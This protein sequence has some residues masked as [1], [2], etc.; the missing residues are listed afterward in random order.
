MCNGPVLKTWEAECINY[1]L[2]NPNIELKLIIRDT[3]ENYG[4][5]SILKKIFKLPLNNIFFLFYSKLIIRPHATRNT[6]LSNIISNIPSITCK[7]IKKGKHSQ[8]FSQEDIL[9]IKGFN[10]DFILRFGF[11]IIRGEILNCSRYGIWSFHHD[12]EQKYRGSPPC[13]WEIYNQ[14]PETGSILQK[15]TDKLDCGIVLKKGILRTKNY[16]YRKNIDQAYFESSKWPLWV[17]NDILNDSAAY[18]FQEPSNSSAKI[19]K[20][21]NNIQFL[22]F[23]LILL[24]NSLNKIFEKFFYKHVWNI[25]LMEGNYKN[26]TNGKKPKLIYQHTLKNSASFNADCF[27]VLKDDKPFIFY[28]ELNKKIS[29]KASLKAISIS[30]KEI[31]YYDIDLKTNCHLS[32]PYLFEE[33]KKLFLIPESSEDK[34]I[35]LFECRSFP[36]EWV[37][38]RDLLE[39]E[40]FIDPSLLKFNNKYWLFYTINSRIYDGDVHLHISYS[41]TLEGPYQQHPM[42]PV[43][44]SAKSSRPA[45]TIFFDQDQ[46]IIRPSQNFTKTYGGS[47]IF[48]KIIRLS[49]SEYL[50]EELTELFPLNDKYPDGIHTFSPL[51]ETLFLVDGKKINFRYKL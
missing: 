43:K 44:I 51:N 47:I 46:N 8:Y 36:E 7:V 32:Y 11:N 49:E 2:S 35:S 37:K 28:E 42:N 33:S 26:L 15:L 30:N 34:K 40:N 10:L 41:D 21:P 24:K 38:I 1:L 22:I 9:A 5:K 13:F 16:S 3:P 48:N 14:D 23:L 6:D 27:G 39:G 25:F 18:I 19:Y 45:G 29:K 31:K 50:E 17:C 4:N 12:D 20:A